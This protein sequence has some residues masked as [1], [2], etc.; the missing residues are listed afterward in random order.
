MIETKT[1]LEQKVASL[2]T[3]ADS[4]DEL[5]IEI[6]SYRVQLDALNQEKQMDLER[7]EELVSQTARFELENKN[8]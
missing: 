4:V 6:A 1:L 3:K 2:T 5:Q 7:I 8:K